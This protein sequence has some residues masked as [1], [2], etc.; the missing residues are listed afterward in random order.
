M[1]QR[2][3]IPVLLALLMLLV[4][5]RP[6][7]AQVQHDSQLAAALDIMYGA[8]LFGAD[9]PFGQAFSLATQSLAPGLSGFIESNLASIPL[10]PP[11]LEV[12]SENNELVEVVT[13]FT[14]IFTESS[15]TVGK[16]NFFVGS[17]FSYFNLT[18]IRGQDLSDLQFAFQQDGGGDIIV[19]NMPL[20]INAAVF[21]LYGTYGI[22]N[23]LDVGFALPIVN[24]SM[25]RQATT[26]EVVGEHTGCRYGAG[27]TP[28]QSGGSPL[29]NYFFAG[30]VAI[31]VGADDA[32]E[33][34]P[35]FETIPESETYLNTLALR[36]KYRFPT[37]LASGKLAAVVDMRL[38]VGR[39]EGNV[40]G[41]GHFGTRVTLIA[42]YD[43]FENFKP[44]VNLG[45]QFWNGDDSNSLRFATGFTQRVASKLFFAFD[46]LGKIDIEDPPFLAP[47]DEPSGEATGVEISLAGSTIPALSRD[48]TLNAGLGLQAVFSPSF[49]VYGSALFSLLDRGLQSA[50]APTIGAALYF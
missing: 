16:G 24:L 25:E 6:S 23:R 36:A 12:V 31:D 21:T 18:K 5:A 41:Q 45:A 37:T 46:L 33:A 50:V 9:G 40:L 39:N 22:T 29:V 47:F 27:C 32:I 1:N 13:G 26:F 30:G 8:C 28:G 19:V 20:D 2:R 7:V 11:S 38:P 48:H 17:N 42:E 49:F 43:E 4:S 15:G 34:T 14:P 10:T 35:D 44:F 3:G